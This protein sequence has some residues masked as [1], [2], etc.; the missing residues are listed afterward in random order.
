MKNKTLI[1]ICAVFLIGFVTATNISIMYGQNTSGA[2]I[3]M[4]V[5]SGGRL[6]T[7][8]N[9]VNI[10]SNLVSVSENLTVGSGIIKWNASSSSFIYYNGTTWKEIGTITNAGTAPTNAVMSFNLAS[11]PSGWNLADGTSGTVN[12]TNQF[13]NGEQVQKQYYANSSDGPGSFN[14][15]GTNWTTDRGVAIP[16][17]DKDGNW[18]VRFNIYGTRSYSGTAGES[19]NISGVIF[20][21]GVYQALVA[22]TTSQTVLAG[23][24]YYSVYTIPNANR[25]IHEFA[26]V[27][28]ISL[29]DWEFSGDVELESKPTWA[30]ADA[31]LIYCVKGATEDTSSSVFKLVGNV[32]SM[33][34]NN[35][36]L[37]IAT[38]LS[39]GNGTIWY[40]DSDDKFYYYNKTAWLDIGSG[41]G[42]GESV[43]KSYTETG[44]GLAVGNAVYYNGTAHLKA[45]SND[46][47]KL[48]TGVVSFVNG[49]KIDV[50][51]SG[52]ISGLSGLTAGE[53]YFVSETQEGELLTS[54]GSNFSN[55]LLQALSTTTGIV[56]NWRAYE[57]DLNPV[58]QLWTNESGVATYNGS[59]LIRENLDITGNIT[60]SSDGVVMV[61]GNLNVTGDIFGNYTAENRQYVYNGSDWVGTRS[62]AEGV[63]HI[64]LNDSSRKYD[65]VPENA[66]MSFNQVSCP[67]GWSLADG[68]SGTVNL[69]NQ[70]ING[71][72]VMKQ[73]YA[74]SSD[75]PGSFNIT[76]SST[77]VWTTTRGVM[78]PYK[79]KDG[80]WR[81]RFNVGGTTSSSARTVYTITIEGI[82]FSSSIQSI[83][84]SGNDAVGTTSGR[85]S[86][87]TNTMSSFHASSSNT[88][89]YRYSG[90]VEL[91]S[92]PTWADADASLI[93]C[94]KTAEDSATSNSIWQTIG[95]LITPV[96]SSKDFAIN[97]SDF[98][99]NVSSGRVG[100]GT[101]SPE[102]DLHIGASSGNI[103][104][105]DGSAGVGNLRFDSNRTGTD[106][107]LGLVV[108]Y[109]DGTAVGRI[110]FET[111]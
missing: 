65:A 89:S 47:N 63:Q 78:I 79:D 34:S 100:I 54:Q 24:Q 109:W 7:N 80:N 105:K 32:I 12:L 104:I 40:N 50:T 72:Q 95:N 36:S 29:I 35:Y 110:V 39:I 55:P 41:S 107:H 111:G 38:N 51:Y 43:V 58:V 46:S 42:T 10:T 101:G 66:V 86:S 83:T 73:Y 92:K 4:Q 11:C 37:S 21:D 69:T 8:M 45:I 15:T 102:E 88:T 5:D 1:L 33:F 108:G 61:S 99:V 90:D 87:G 57:I 70:F 94:V 20:K 56:F 93:Y 44:H 19:I 52:Y 25:I 64:F 74:N 2:F 18:R 28:T 85:T 53:Y 22:S 6:K 23:D 17:K 16:Y 59:V 75:G 71:E 67:A 84:T 77:G 3:P 9:L 30:D 76:N 96:N 91:E 81:M 13:I 97:N 106:Q 27:V 14:I 62:T 103:L 68:T 48:G 98:Y 60:S 26:S 82:N 31:S 49:D